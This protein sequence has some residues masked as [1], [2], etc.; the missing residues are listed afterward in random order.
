MM[1]VDKVSGKRIALLF[2]AIISGFILNSQIF[3]QAEITAFNFDLN[4]TYVETINPAT[5]VIDVEI[6]N[7]ADITGLVAVFTVSANATVKIGTVDQVS[8]TTVNNFTNQVTYTVTS[9]DGSVTKV[10]KV[11]V[12]KRVASSE[13]VLTAF[14]FA[15]IPGAVGVIDQGTHTV[16]VTVPYSQNV[17]SLVATFT[18]SPLASAKVGSVVQVSGTTANNYT[19]VLAFFV[20]A[21]NG[22]S[23]RY[24]ITVNKTAARTEKQLLTFDFN[25][26]DPD[27]IGV[28][29]QA[30]FTVTLTVPFEVDE[31]DLVAYFTSSPLS[32]IKVGTVVQT[33]GSTTNDFTAPLDYTVVAEDG[34]TQDYVVTVNKAAAST[35]K[36]ITV[37]DFTNLDPDVVGIINEGAKTIALTI[38]FSADI[39]ALV[40]TFTVSQFASVKIG[41]VVQVSGTNSN[42]FTNPVDY[43]VEAQDG[44]KVTYTV[45]V[46]QTAAS[47][48]NDMLTFDFKA[49]D[50]TELDADVPGNIDQGAKTITLEVPYGTVV[51][52]L[53]P[54]FTNSPLSDVS[55]GGTAQVSGTTPQNFTNNV[56]YTV[57][58]EDGSA[59]I[60]TVTVTEAGASQNN[61]LIT[62]DF[63]ALDPDVIGV[64]DQVAKT[65][66]LHVPFATDLTTLV[67]TFTVSDFA[68]AKIGTVVQQS[69][70]TANDFTNPVV[71]SIIAQ[72]GSTELY[73]VTVIIDPNTEKK[74][75]SY[76][77]QQISPIAG[78]SIDHTNHTVVVQ[79]AYSVDRSA[80]VASFVVSAHATVKI[81]ATAQ[82]SGLTPNDFTVVQTYTITAQDGSTQDYQVT[83][84]NQAISSA[85]EITAFSFNA[86]DPV[87]TADIDQ[88]AFTID[89]TVPKGTNVTAL[90]ATFTNSALSNVAVGGVAQTS[91]T[92]ANDFTNPIDYVVTAE[93][94]S[95]ATY[96]VTV[97]I[98]PLSAEN[99]LTYFAFEALDPTVVGA[100]NQVSKTVSMIVPNGTNRTNLVATF[101]ISDFAQLRI[102]GAGAGFQ[103]SGQTSNDYS[104]SRVYEVIAEDGSVKQY[105]VTVSETNDVTA[106]IVTVVTT[107]GNNTHANEVTN[108]LGQFA[109]VKS[110]EASGKVYIIEEDAP[111]T[112][113]ADLEA[114]VAAGKGKAA[115]VDEAN[116]NIPISTYAMDEGT[117]YAYA[118]DAA[119]NKSAKSTIA[120][121]IDDELAPNVIIAAQTISNAPNNSVVAQSTE[122]EGFIYLVKDDV[123]QA[124]KGQL[125]A[126]VAAKNGVKGF[127]FASFT[128]I[129]LPVAGLNPGTYHAYAVDNNANLSDASTQVV[130]ITAAS[131]LK[132]MSSFSF[133]GTVP[134]SIGHIAGTLIDIEVP[135]GTSLTNL[136]ASFTISEKAKAYIGLVEQVSGVTANNFTNPITYTVEAEDGTTLDYIMTVTVASGTG[137]N[138]IQWVDAIQVYPNPVKDQFSIEM[139]KPVDRVVVTDMLG[140]I[141]VDIDKPGTDMIQVSTQSWTSGLFIVRFYRHGETVYHRKLIKQ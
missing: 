30:A 46:N 49:T 86:F 99:E 17:T 5:Q 130:I 114:S 97:T 131:R 22:S 13:K 139:L 140:Q 54:T 23:R 79:V 26:L 109:L 106:P 89:A 68:S 40:T 37:F 15:A 47:Q 134:A 96:T 53:V 32:T 132:S 66:T 81:A 84:T 55:V 135:Y 51:T 88:A 73:T 121:T 48:A 108:K 102:T 10:W 105:T 14:E 78:G 133:Q 85:K 125:D 35:A 21:E 8:G 107:D 29:D 136:V 123:P 95:T 27:V 93:D 43:I 19:N 116:T 61:Q 138:D 9:Q 120:I 122:N 70:V 76:S 31:T 20:V 119:S 101:T 60:Y 115:W 57:T 83:V 110:N 77:F 91:G 50:N 2:A 128:N 129:T 25:D 100:I 52:S 16:T 65:V 4:P 103:T 127:V 80:L 69:G 126:A 72:D 39:T 58:A 28:I 74:F 87:V 82:V 90:V 3:A 38:P 104:N 36:Q 67:A 62:F 71:Y 118:I 59:E 41:A 33:S 18:L 1:K 113:V 112:T 44:S 124:T 56:L 98:V 92:S 7:S 141:V 6:Y 34:S 111:Q 64:I 45:T 117:Y 24:D 12:T 11:N 42:D 75:I 137:I 94:G 63:V